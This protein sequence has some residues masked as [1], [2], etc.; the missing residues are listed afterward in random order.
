MDLPPS[1]L[2]ICTRNRFELLNDTID[3]ILDAQDVPSELVIVDQSDTPHPE[4]EGRKNERGCAIRYV[5]LEVIG[6]SHA[7]NAGIQAAR[8]DL[9][10]FIDDDMWVA[11]D[12]YGALLQALICAGPD[13]V[14]TGRV[15]PAPSEKPAGFVI[16]VHAWESTQEYRGR[17]GKDVLA[18]GHLA[19][20]RSAYQK[21]GGLDERLGPGTR[22]PG[23]EDNDYGYR[24]LEAGYRIIYAADSVIYHRAW[25]TRKDYV[26]LFWK[27][28]RGQGAFYAKH[29][30]WKD[31]YMLQRMRQDYARF[32]RLLPGRVIHGQ[33]LVIRGSSAF[34]LGEWLGALEWWLTRRKGAA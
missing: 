17:I 31:R 1:S 19:M 24:L 14:V 23:A 2:I 32:L 3:S 7:R 15:V 12:W 11:P 21:I 9:L 16:A 20:Y 34:V 28:G 33:L 29:W 22:F 8:H 5:W 10:A 27:Y 18:T 26:P 30:S 25:R 4:L 13:A 6:S